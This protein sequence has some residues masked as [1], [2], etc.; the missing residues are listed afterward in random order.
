[1]LV[2]EPRPRISDIIGLSELV[3]DL[4]LELCRIYRCYDSRKRVPS[5]SASVLDRCF[6]HDCYGVPIKKEA[7]Q[8]QKVNVYKQKD[9]YPVLPF[10]WV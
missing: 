9:D 5:W 4:G 1:M 10:D 7:K 2:Y 8:K 6:T 3:A